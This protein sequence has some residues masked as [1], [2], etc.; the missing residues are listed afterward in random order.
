VIEHAYFDNRRCSFIADSSSVSA[1]NRHCKG[2]YRCRHGFFAESMPFQVIVQI[3]GRALRISK[4]AQHEA[5]MKA[6]RCLLYCCAAHVFWCK[7]RK[8]PY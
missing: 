1:G 2:F 5:M 3:E 6:R 7:Q 4:K 8:P